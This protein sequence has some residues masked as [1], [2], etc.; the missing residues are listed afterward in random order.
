MP[1]L[2]HKGA[3]ACAQP[4]ADGTRGWISPHVY[5]F[6]D[7]TK[8]TVGP[9]AAGAAPALSRRPNRRAASPRPRKMA[10]GLRPARDRALA[11]PARARTNGMNGL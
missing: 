4:L 7:A 9:S 11:P 8:A 3:A 6:S 10:A 2:L 5:V 1:V